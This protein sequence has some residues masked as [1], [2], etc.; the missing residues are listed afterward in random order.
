MTDFIRVFIKALI[1]LL[2]SVALLSCGGGDDDSSMSLEEQKQFVFD[3]MSDYYLYYDRMPTI[4]L[5]DYESPEA[6]LAALMVNPPDRFSYISNR[7]LQ[8]TLFEEGRFEGI[9]YGRI[10]NSDGTQT[11]IYVFDES[12]AG[13]PC[14]GSF[15][16]QSCLQR[17][18]IIRSTS[19]VGNTITF[20]VDRNGSLF[21]ADLTIATVQINTVLR[22]D[23]QTLNGLNIGYLALHRFFEPTVE[24]LDRAFA[25]FKQ[26]N[27]DELV[28]DLR[29]NTGG[30][31]SVAQ[32]LA[33]YIAG[34]NGRN[35]DVTRLEWN[36]R[37]TQENDRYPFLELSNQLNLNRLYVLTLE[38]TCSASELVINAMTGIGVDVIT[39][40]Q[41]TCGK[42]VGSVSFNFGDKVL[43]PLTF[44]VVNDLGNGDYFSGIDATC[45]ADD[46]TD[47]Q[48]S[49]PNELM[50]AGAL[51]HIVNGTCAPIATRSFN[52]AQ[53]L[54]YNPDPMAHL[55]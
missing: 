45:Y 42:P 51:Y 7:I 20:N 40:G 11:V 24:E 5:A 35:A 12:A 43:Q 17:G 38:S 29:Y 1:T 34:L 47:R 21:S 22:T 49:D 36:D 3:I 9:G 31:V 53:T 8:Q 6:V 30:R 46:D 19:R 55:F 52:K 28:V 26:N 16:T 4:D 33:S 23:I 10:N 41:P 18:D 37:N 44:S 39:V 15:S 13:R 48:F 50:Y 2:L 25:E 27:V 14:P 32:V 54:P